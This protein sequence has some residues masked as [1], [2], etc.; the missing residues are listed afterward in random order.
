MLAE[1]AIQRTKSKPEENCALKLAQL[2]DPANIRTLKTSTDDC[3][4][5]LFDAYVKHFE[6]EFNSSIDPIPQKKPRLESHQPTMS[7]ASLI[8]DSNSSN[9]SQGRNLRKEIKVSLFN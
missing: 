7:L 3:V 4:E 9:E 5:L 1:F 6:D 8:N 2:F